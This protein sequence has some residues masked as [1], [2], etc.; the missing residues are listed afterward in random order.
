MKKNIYLVGFMGTGKSTI[1]RELAKIMGR[2][3]LDMDHLMEKRFSMTV[4]QIY[5]TR[6][7]TFFREEEKKLAF[8]LIELRNKVISTGGGTL[9][10]DEVRQAFRQN[11][12]MICLTADYNELVERLSRTDK[13]PNLRG[14][15]IQEKI[16]R[17]LL[18]R[19]DIFDQIPIKINTTNNTPKETAGKIIQLFK[20]RQN[21][22]DKLQN[23][24]L[25]IS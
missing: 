12:I 15:N 13:R 19:R 1:G 11:G 23:G 9:L 8:E 4:N 2:Q 5:D 20:I 21:V 7:E 17:L 24:Y 22:L 10:D 18:E 25:D 16:T 14:E 3:F 6:G